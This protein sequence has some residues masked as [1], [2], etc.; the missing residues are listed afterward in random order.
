M[1]AGSHLV[2]AAAALSVLIAEPG[3]NLIA[4]AIPH[5]TLIAVAFAIRSVVAAGISFLSR[6]GIVFTTVATTAAATAVGTLASTAV[7][8]PAIA[9]MVAAPITVVTP[10]LVAAVALAAGALP[11]STR[12]RAP[13]ILAPVARS[14][15]LACIR[16]AAEAP[17]PLAVVLLAVA[18]RAIV[19]AWL[20]T[21]AFTASAEVLLAARLPAVALAV[22]VP[23]AGPVLA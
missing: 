9:A 11:V 2:H 14:G 3:G 19:L 13:F 20:A 4:R 1:P 6:T 12:N 22:L 5:A 8:S 15:G 17:A 23:T 21:I 10:S 18:P 7:F 16:A